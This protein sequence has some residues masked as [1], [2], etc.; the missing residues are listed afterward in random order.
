MLLRQVRALGAGLG[1]DSEGRRLVL[2]S[3]PR[4]ILPALNTEA[5]RAARR[6]L[7]WLL[8]ACAGGPP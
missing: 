8:M 4:C 5:L 1:N 6:L 7:R 3:S 2:S